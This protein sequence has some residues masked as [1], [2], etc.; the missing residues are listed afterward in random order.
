MGEKTLK[1][2]IKKIKNMENVFFIIEISLKMLYNDFMAKMKGDAFNAFKGN[3]DN[4][5]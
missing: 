5:R 1:I 3:K 4:H 2:T